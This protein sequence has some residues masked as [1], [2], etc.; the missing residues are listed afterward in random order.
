M[1]K[2]KKRIVIAV[3]TVAI[4]LIIITVILL[5]LYI[6]TDAFKSNKTLFK[7][8]L[9]QNIEDIINIASLFEKDDYDKLL[10]ENKYTNNTQITM[11]YTEGI[12]TTSE[13]SDSSINNLKLN[14]SGQ[15]D[16]QEKYN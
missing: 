8:Y 3:T 1:V 2:K 14:I 4:F 9:G 15:V 11:N 7:K 10:E 13:K 6:T 5:T 12:G 16:N